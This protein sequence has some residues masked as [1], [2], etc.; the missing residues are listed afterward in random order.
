M[1]WIYFSTLI[2]IIFRKNPKFR[3]SQT[4]LRP[5]PP[6]PPQNTRIIISISLSHQ[7]KNKKKIRSGFKWMYNFLERD[8]FCVLFTPTLTHCV[9]PPKKMCVGIGYDV[10]YMMDDD[11]VN[12]TQGGRGKK[13]GETGT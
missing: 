4:G 11:H 2:L 3:S 10:R 8:S 9:Q 6:L 13:G 5:P 12:V 7:K 1:G